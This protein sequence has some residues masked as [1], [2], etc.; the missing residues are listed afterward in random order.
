MMNLIKIY[1]SM[2]GKLALKIGNEDE[3]EK[4]FR[5]ALALDPELTEAALT[6]NKLLLHQE[7][8]EDVI[9]IIKHN[10]RWWRSGTTFSMGCCCCLSKSRRIFRGIKS[11]MKAHIL[12]IKIQLI[13]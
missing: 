2:A 5:E 4:M 12:F 10:G 7:R 11:T 3:A 1:F 13:F 6:L 9:E 8:Y